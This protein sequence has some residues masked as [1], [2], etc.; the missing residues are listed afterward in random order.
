MLAS[1]R[2]GGFEGF[3]RWGSE[4]C[5]RLRKRRGGEGGTRWVLRTVAEEGEGDGMEVCRR[6]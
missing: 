6:L 4:G 2:K 5:G 3:R 1:G